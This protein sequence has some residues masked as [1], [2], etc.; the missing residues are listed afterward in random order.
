MVKETIKLL[1]HP[2]MRVRSAIEDRLRRPFKFVESV[3]K[4]TFASSGKVPASRYA[5][6]GCLA[7]FAED[8]DET[9]TATARE[10]EREDGRPTHK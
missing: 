1:P 8:H 4:S 2:N 6:W 10:I 3:F 9:V 5:A 7:Q